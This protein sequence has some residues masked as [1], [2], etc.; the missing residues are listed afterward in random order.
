MHSLHFL[1]MTEQSKTKQGAQVF[2]V[3]LACMGRDVDKALGA[4]TPSFSIAAL[5]RSGSNHLE[6]EYN[7]KKTESTA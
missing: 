7:V 6:L 1:Y 4:S 2:I 3:W 5:N